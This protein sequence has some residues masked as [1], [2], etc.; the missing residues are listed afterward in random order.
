M[1][2]IPG[3]GLTTTIFP[4]GTNG[5]G[6][7]SPTSRRNPS[8][9]GT[10]KKIATIVKTP[11]K[12]HGAFC[13]LLYG[14][15]VL[16]ITVVHHNTALSQDI[17]RTVEFEDLGFTSPLNVGARP[18]GM[19]GA[20]AA[21]GNDVYSLVYNPAGLARVKRFEISLGVRQERGEIK[22]TFYG[23]PNTIDSHDGG[24]DGVGLAWPLTTYQGSFVI[25]AGVFRSYSGVFDL[26]YNGIN[27]ATNTADNF[28]LQQTGSV[29]SYNLGIG[30]DLSPSLSGGFALF[31]LDGHTNVLRQANFTYLDRAPTTSV[32]VKEDVSTDLSGIGVRV[33]VQFFFYQLVCGG[34]SFTTPTWTENKGGG[35]REITTHKDNA[36]DSF[37]REKVEVNDEYLLPYRID[38]GV[39]FTPRFLVLALEIGYADWTE[40]S[41]DRKRFRDNMTLET[42]F[43][44]V[45]D[46]KVGAELTLPR[47]PVR[48]RAGFAYRP[49]PLAYLQAD[50]IDEND[51]TKAVVERERR[52]IAFGL[53]GLIG[54]MLTVDA[55]LSLT[56]GKRTIDAVTD[57]RTSR[58]FVLSAAYR[59]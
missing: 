7:L 40:A 12:T 47:I 22:N 37:E 27:E 42:I 14:F 23:N 48:A 50:R 34:V 3:S 9:P 15:V 28:L 41:I 18:S 4:G 1:Q 38:V 56:D 30:V 6:I 33:G 2:G 57:E 29:Y 24:I 39:A 17:N 25:A 54:D 31:I 10:T 59:F 44:E 46:Y 20:F 21:V 51:I 55:S 43:K 11:N 58:R 16:A 13:A 45:F 52:E 53:G 26:H 32:F 36:I 5:F 19:A 8:N 49:Y 35:V